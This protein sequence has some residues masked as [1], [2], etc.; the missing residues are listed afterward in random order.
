MLFDVRNAAAA[1]QVGA[2]SGRNT[3]RRVW[4]HTE[5]FG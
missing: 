5:N 1:A 3:A 2:L 4:L